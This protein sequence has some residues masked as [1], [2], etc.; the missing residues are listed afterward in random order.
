[1]SYD[2]EHG[3][4]EARYRKEIESQHDKLEAD[5]DERFLHDLASDD[6][7]DYIRSRWVN[8]EISDDKLSRR[9]PYAFRDYFRPNMGETPKRDNEIR[10][11]QPWRGSGYIPKSV[12][13]DRK[14]SM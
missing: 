1:M 5:A 14:K 9:D 8:G 10:K 7:D 6:F 11:Q 12:K 13:L 3:S 2:W 4:P